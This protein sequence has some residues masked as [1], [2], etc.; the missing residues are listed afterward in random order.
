LFI[1]SRKKLEKAINLLNQQ[2]SELYNIGDAIDENA[3]KLFNE[4]IDTWRDRT[5]KII[6]EYLTTKDVDLFQKQVD[7]AT[8]DDSHNFKIA[9]VERVTML[10]QFVRKFTDDLEHR[11]QH[12]KKLNTST[13]K[14]SDIDEKSSQAKQA[15]LRQIEELEKLCIQPCESVVDISDD[16]YDYLKECLV[17]WKDRTVIVLSK[18]VSKEEGMRFRQKRIKRSYQKKKEI[19]FR[20]EAKQYHDY[21]MA[22][23]VELEK[24]P[25]HVLIDSEGDLAIATESTSIKDSRAHEV[26]RAEKVDDG[27]ERAWWKDLKNP[28][29][30]VVIIGLATL[31]AMI[32]FGFKQMER[33]RL[34]AF[35][36]NLNRA[37]IVV[38]SINVDSMFMF[39]KGP[40]AG[41][42]PMTR[43]KGPVVFYFVN[44]GE[45]DAYPVMWGCGID[46][47]SMKHLHYRDSL[48]AGKLTYTP[49]EDF[50]ETIHSNHK[51][52][53]G[54]FFEE[55]STDCRGRFFIHFYIIYRDI[56]DD[57]HDYYSVV[58]VITDSDLGTFKKY[59]PIVSTYTFKTK[60]IP[61]IYAAIKKY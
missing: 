51:Y 9:A 53:R 54:R 36:K 55:K 17:R 20:E 56:F 45:S 8:W 50:T 28:G 52:R 3:P 10:S 16:D 25:E 41:S 14:K 43:F 7:Q 12:L 37:N 23:K 32:F 38:D 47:L 44:E 18:S 30:W 59:E 19:L 60:E 35:E 1:M 2:L 33:G 31:A 24:H 61:K 13:E 40:L 11:L 5:K 26:I 42:F 22:L 57:Y 15:L 27:N 58:E 34:S 39:S 46:T 4:K 6:S 49:E 21:L 29:L 48:L